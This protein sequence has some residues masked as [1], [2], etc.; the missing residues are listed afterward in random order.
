MFV[1]TQIVDPQLQIPRAARTPGFLGGWFAVEEE[2]VGFKASPARTA[3][4]IEDAGG[5][6]QQSMD[7]ALFD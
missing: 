2:D 4:R 1:G 7:V 5:Q 3:L 6:T